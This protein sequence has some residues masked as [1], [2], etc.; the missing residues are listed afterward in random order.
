MAEAPRRPRVLSGMRPTGMLHLGHLFL[1]RKWVELQ[2]TSDCSFFV[3]D[4]HALTTGVRNEREAK[5]NSIDMLVCWLA[6]G[7]DPERS[8]LFIQSQLREHAE[9]HLVL[10]MVCPLPWLERVPSFK[11][12]ADTAKR[13][14]LSYG[15][16][17]YP[18]LQAADIIAHSA[19][20]VP[21]GD[22]Q[23]AH[24]ELAARVARTFNDR[25][26]K[27]DG[28]QERLAELEEQLPDAKEYRRL[29]QA[30]AQDGDA[31]ARGKARELVDAA[32]LGREA[33]QVLR[34][35]AD[36]GGREILVP[37]APL[38]AEVSRLAGLDG[39]AKM[40]KSERNDIGMLEDR[41]SFAAKLKAM[42][43]DPARVRRSDPGTPAKC[44]VYGYHRLFSAEEIQSQVAEGCQSAGIGC[45]EC[46][47]LLADGIE[48]QVAPL[49]QRAEPWLRDRDKIDAIIK[50]GNDR[51]RA[52]AAGVLS[53]VRRAVGLPQA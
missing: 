18:V 28:W 39:Q 43:T 22:D 34:G 2:E 41:E 16:L 9:L 7:L 21:V 50:Q 3:A 40:S 45:I 17:G 29:R 47:G 53:D 38:K 5:A 37:P 12:K 1:L 36:G 44:P 25:F 31:A 11:D 35:G 49:R 48:A 13:E 52:H 46:K 8:T 15:L 19:D 24:V 10:S 51:A 27:P 30:A 42:P 14:D 6:A 20:H 32:E 33:R 26:G 4:Y 23:E